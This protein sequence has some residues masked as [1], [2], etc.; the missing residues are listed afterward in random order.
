[1]IEVRLVLLAKVVVEVV[2]ENR[3]LVEVPKDRTLR[4]GSVESNNGIARKGMGVGGD[5]SWP[6]GLV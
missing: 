1:M 6:S 4:E 5:G 3:T 2:P